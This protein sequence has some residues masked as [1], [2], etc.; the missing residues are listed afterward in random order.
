MTI[1]GHVDNLKVSHYDPWEIT[2][3]VKYLSKICG[4]IKVKKEKIHKNLDM[5]LENSTTVDIRVSM[6]PYRQDDI[7]TFR[8]SHH[9]GKI[10]SF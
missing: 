9:T 7:K 6:I 5:T 4:D 3:L 2:S 10:L 1:V 8:D